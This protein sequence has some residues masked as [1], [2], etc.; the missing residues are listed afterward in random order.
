MLPP[1][2]WV[3]DVKRKLTTVVWPSDY[4]PLLIFQVGSDEV[5]TRSLRAIKRYFRALG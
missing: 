3:K 2:A 4:Y 5:T 1:G